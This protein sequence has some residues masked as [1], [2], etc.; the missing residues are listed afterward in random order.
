MKASAELTAADVDELATSW[1][2]AQSVGQSSAEMVMDLQQ[3]LSSAPTTYACSAEVTAPPVAAPHSTGLLQ[4]RQTS[5]VNVALESEDSGVP[6]ASSDV[7]EQSEAQTGVDQPISAASRE[8]DLEQA[9]A[10]KRANMNAQSAAEP[11]SRA[12]EVNRRAQKRFR[13]KQKAGTRTHSII[14][15]TLQQ[16]FVVC[17]HSLQIM[18]GQLHG[19]KSDIQ[20]AGQ[21]TRLAGRETLL[22]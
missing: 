22:K 2:N 20:K 8:F 3:A 16:D 12:V 6:G 10:A 11:P 4:G 5:D 14:A 18:Y 9:P 19:L 21:E 1:I 13:L 7:Q 17:I 15:C